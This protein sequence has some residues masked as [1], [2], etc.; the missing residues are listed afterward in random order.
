MKRILVSI[1]VANWAPDV[2]ALVS[3]FAKQQDVTV[4]LLYVL[5]L[6]IMASENRVYEE[7][8]REAQW[9]LERL[10]HEYLPVNVTS[11]IR[12]RAGKLAEE[13]VAEAKAQQVDAT[14]LPSGHSS[15]WKRLPV[16]TLFRKIGQVARE[17]GCGVLLARA[18]T[19]FDCRKV[20]GRQFHESSPRRQRAPDDVLATNL[21]A[22]AVADSSEGSDQEH[23]LPA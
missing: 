9:R 11:L 15:F 18:K 19:R 13:I 4:I 8:G 17:S 5:N 23:R 3:G 2:F 1:D 14:I 20:W 10:A 6:N 7:L 12:V 21:D 22:L 16:P